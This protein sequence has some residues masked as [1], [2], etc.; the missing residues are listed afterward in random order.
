[1][2]RAI[3]LHCLLMVPLM[4]CS[5]TDWEK[6][7]DRNG[8]VIYTRVSEDNPLKEYRAQAK[9]NYPIL[10]VYEFSIDLERRPEWVIRCMGMEILDTI[11]DGLIRYHTR[12]DVPWPLADRDL[13]VSADLSFDGEKARLLTVSTELDYPLEEGM[14]R[15]K[16]YREDVRLEKL[17]PQRTLFR[18]EGFADPGGTLPPW[19]INMFLVDGIY[20]S[21]I[22]TREALEKDKNKSTVD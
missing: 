10:D 12:Y 5:Q 17:D 13:V 3:P 21:V 9:I 18:A 7:R 11:E 15:M 4:V 22:A 20:D 6:K 8:I 1:M 14:I 16:S 2:N 19:I